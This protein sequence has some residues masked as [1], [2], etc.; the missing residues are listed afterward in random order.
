M[1][2]RL[3]WATD[4]HLEFCEDAGV[5]AFLDALNAARPDA[6]LLTGDIGQ[7][8]SIASFLQRIELGTS[9]PIYYVLGNHD[10]YKGSIAAVRAGLSATSAARA[11]WLR[12]DGP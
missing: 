12:A 5:A 3:A 1:T 8:P 2:F 7:A 4:I 6:V 9:C 11:S 10:F